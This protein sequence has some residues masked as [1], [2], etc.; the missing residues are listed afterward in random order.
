MIRL[1]AKR[2]E[3]VYVVLQTVREKLSRFQVRYNEELAILERLTP[4][5]R[6][7]DPVRRNPKGQCVGCKWYEPVDGQPCLWKLE[8][9]IDKASQHMI[10]ALKIIRS[11]TAKQRSL[12]RNQSFVTEPFPKEAKKE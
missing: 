4:K 6:E 9:Q 1:E 8:S 12:V 11:V 10:Q 3:R 2:N 5:R 7:F